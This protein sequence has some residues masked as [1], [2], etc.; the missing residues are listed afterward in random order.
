[1]SR[2][3]SAELQ[4]LTSFPI[5]LIRPSRRMV[6]HRKGGWLE[7][8]SLSWLIEDRNLDIESYGPKINQLF[9]PNAYV[10]NKFNTH[11]PACAWNHFI[12]MLIQSRSY[13]IGSRDYCFVESLPELRRPRHGYHRTKDRRSELAELWNRVGETIEGDDITHWYITCQWAF[14]IEKVFTGYT[15]QSSAYDNV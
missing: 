14:H 5:E 13:V 2:A 7:K 15:N 1:M 10:Q 12:E 9:C 4:R 3:S 11:P 6:S 8:K